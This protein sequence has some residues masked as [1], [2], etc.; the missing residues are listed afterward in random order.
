MR[1]GHCAAWTAALQLCRLVTVALVLFTLMNKLLPNAK[2]TWRAALVGGL[3]TA[4]AFEVAK[5]GFN[6]YINLGTARSWAVLSMP[7]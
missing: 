2:V 5:W 3:F 4:V 7:P 1:P 6:Q